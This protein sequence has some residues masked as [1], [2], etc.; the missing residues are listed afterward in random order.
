MR[1]ILGLLL[2][3]LLPLL[4][5]ATPSFQQAQVIR[6]VSNTSPTCNDQ[7]PCYS[8]IQ[9]AI[10]AAQAGDIVRIQAGQYDEAV[11]IKKRVFRNSSGSFEGVNRPG[12]GVDAGFRAW[13]GSAESANRFAWRP[14]R[15]ECGGC[16]MRTSSPAFVRNPRCAVFSAI[17]RRG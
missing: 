11:S 1:K 3:A 16:G 14:Q 12:S 15:S 7:S 9:A 2:V 13:S 4:W 5:L 10:D 8:T 6:Y 17:R